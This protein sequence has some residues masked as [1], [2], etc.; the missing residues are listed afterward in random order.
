MDQMQPNEELRLPRGQ[1]ADGVRIPN[2][3]KQG[4]VAHDPM[5][6][7]FKRLQ[8]LQKEQKTIVTGPLLS[9]ASSG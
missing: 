5:T 4:A 2:L 1:R 3:I 7:V 9:T 8:W 6:V